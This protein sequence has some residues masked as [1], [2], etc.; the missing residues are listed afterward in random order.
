MNFQILFHSILFSTASQS[1]TGKHYMCES[2]ITNLQGNLNAQT[3]KH[4]SESFCL[5]V[6]ETILKKKELLSYKNIGCVHNILINKSTVLHPFFRQ[7]EWSRTVVLLCSLHFLK[8]SLF[9][10]TTT[11][12][13]DVS[14]CACRHSCLPIVV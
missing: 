5:L 13:F 7:L 2:N 1:P 8:C 11:V 10:V 14:V 4:S 6:I 12:Y 9:F 3:P